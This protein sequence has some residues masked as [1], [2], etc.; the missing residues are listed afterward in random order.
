MIYREEKGFDGEWDKISAVIHDGIDQFGVDSIPSV[1]LVGPRQ[2]SPYSKARYLALL[3]KRGNIDWETVVSF[4]G[5]SRADVDELVAAYYD[6]ERHYRP[7]VDAEDKRFDPSRF[8]TFVVLQ[9]RRVSSAVVDA[10]FDKDDYARWV[11]ERKIM[12]SQHA[13]AIPRILSNKHAKDIFIR[14]GS[15]AA[16]N[17]LTSL[18]ENDDKTLSDAPMELLA[19][20]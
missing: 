5:G 9:Q 2:W 8:S 4:C 6:M 20:S 7:I 3:E 19:K 15:Q 12:P 13:R 18:G 14:D 17:Y 1:T 10:G 16:L 11:H